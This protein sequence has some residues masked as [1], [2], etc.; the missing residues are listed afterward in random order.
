MVFTVDFDT[1]FEETVAQIYR[2]KNKPKINPTTKLWQLLGLCEDL[3]QTAY[4]K[5]SLFRDYMNTLLERSD[6]QVILN[7]FQKS[8]DMLVILIRL[9]K[10]K[11]KVYLAQVSENASRLLE[12][13]ETPPSIPCPAFFETLEK[14]SNPK[15][16]LYLLLTKFPT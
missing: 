11:L 10:S 1:L 3:L 12:R 8:D 6:N 7:G 9:E 4:F 14:L 16:A 2:E 13:N 15:T 5:S